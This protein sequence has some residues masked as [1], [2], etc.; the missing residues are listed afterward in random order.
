MTPS[1]T[2]PDSGPLLSQSIVARLHV[3][4]V[5]DLT[6]FDRD[7]KYPRERPRQIGKGFDTPPFVGRTSVSSVRT[8]V[9][10]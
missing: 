7:H 3:F 8:E 1:N 10:R 4:S 2:I 9:D 6:I 5:A